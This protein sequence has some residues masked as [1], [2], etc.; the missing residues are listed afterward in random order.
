M[1]HMFRFLVPA[2]TAVLLVGCI[3][4]ETT[5]RRP[6]DSNEDAADQ[7]Y[8]LGAQ[9]YSKG[10]FELARERLE[11]AVELDSRNANAHSMLALTYARL[12]NERLA[13]EN[14]NKAVRIAPNNFDVRNAYAIYLCGERDFEEARKQFDRAIAVREN[15]NSEFMM[16]NAGVCMAQ[17]PDNELAEK[18]F[19]DALAKRPNYKDALLQLATLKH[20]TGDDLSARAFLQRYLATNP[21]TAMVLYLGVQIE[22]ALDDERA[23]TDYS[24]QIL[25]DFPDSPEANQVLRSGQAMRQ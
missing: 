4:S 24:N 25:R 3:S 20:H 10:N 1:M 7:L 12:G 2:M 21:P 19:R 23:A 8:N 17:K 18:Y 16:S 5:S 15:D 13:T 14:F 6:P 9:Y 22:S 11:R